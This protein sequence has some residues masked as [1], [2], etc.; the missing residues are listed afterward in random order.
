MK[1]IEKLNSSFKY[2]VE[3]SK[4]VKI[5]YENIDKIIGDLEKRK[6]SF[7][8]ESNPFGLF[9]MSYEDIVNF[10]LI[11]HTIGYCFWG[12]PKWTIETEFGPL[13]GS[14][15][16]MYVLINRYKSNSDF[17]M[18]YEEFKKMLKGNIEIPLLENRYSRLSMMNEILKKENKSFFEM[19]RNIEKDSELLEL[20]IEKFPYF[21]DISEYKG[22]KVYFYK[23]AQLLTS[24]V[25]HVME[26]KGGKK[27]DYS[28]LVGCADYKIPQVLRCYGI[29]EFDLSL[30][31]KVDSKTEILS[32]SEEEIEIR[33]C[34]LEVIDYIYKKTSGKYSKIEI[35][36]FI[37]LMG[38]DKSKITK[39]Y[40]RTLTD[41][42]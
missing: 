1:L 38:Q 16:M 22:E 33:A 42:Y 2:V 31:T 35:N 41:R 32:Q 27:V 39:P 23:L 12:E 25:L 28:H 9:D 4:H 20:I 18:N 5:N 21:E 17:D 37:W 36:D 11:N 40:H 6:S 26:L 7:W 8:L 19:V 30:A 34:D 10:L 3:N 24:D 14:Y 15:A 13:D 29:L